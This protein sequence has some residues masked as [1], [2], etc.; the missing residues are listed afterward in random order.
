MKMSGAMELTY[1]GCEWIMRLAYLNLLWIGFT[2]IGFILVGFFPS[3]VAMFAVTRKW[4]MG[5]K[6]V[7]TFGVFWETY[8]LKF[9][10]SNILMLLLMIIGAVFY[11][12]FMI[13]SVLDGWQYRLITVALLTV[14]INFLVIL[15]NIFPMF[16]HYEYSILQYLKH[17][18]LFG[19]F[20]PFTTI[21]I[22]SIIAVYFLLLIILPSLILFFSGSV[23]SFIMMSITYRSIKRMENKYKTIKKDHKQ[24]KIIGAL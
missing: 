14:F 1:R 18:L 13:L 6:D 24:R 7:S 4:V 12:D 11:F 2:F 8:R 5:E 9:I 22:A 23:I 15:L 17:S 21:L 16:V 19:L 3:T 10:K 20:N